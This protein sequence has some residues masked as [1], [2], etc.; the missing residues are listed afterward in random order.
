VGEK[1]RGGWR[2]R[3][4]CNL[5]KRVDSWGG[6]DDRGSKMVVFGNEQWGGE[7]KH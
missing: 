3:E 6:L 5:G 2:G 1:K 4:T 7:R